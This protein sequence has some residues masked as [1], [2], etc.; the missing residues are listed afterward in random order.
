MALFFTLPFGVIKATTN[1]GP[2]LNVMS[3]LVIGSLYESSTQIHVHCSVG[4]NYSC[5]NCPF[6][7]SLVASDIR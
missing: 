1:K 5:F 6:R 2:G 4:W 7:H 3:E